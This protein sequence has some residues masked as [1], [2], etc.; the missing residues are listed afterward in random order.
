MN[1]SV[2]TERPTEV[3]AHTEV[4]RIHA[5]HAT[6]KRLGRWTSA[7][8]YEVHARNGSVVLDLRS[9]DL[10]AEV[11]IRL[12]LDHA[13]IK[14]LLPDEASVE[15]WDLGWTGRGKVKDS[16]AAAPRPQAGDSAS[17]GDAAEQERRLEQKQ[18]RGQQQSEEAERTAEGV[19]RVRLLG[20]AD[21]SEVRIN[22]GGI[23]MLAAMCS[24]EYVEE[25]RQ[26]R[27]EG[28]YPT[29]DDPRRPAKTAA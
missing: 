12:Q 23:A 15:H 7:D 5:D 13:A 19:R 28:T 6:V 22:R 11:E 8:S 3:A 25:L 1:Q 24:R 20:S 10:P 29:I 9:P 4:E 2:M 17:H 26:A 14:L 21:G 18:D 16:Q 27:K